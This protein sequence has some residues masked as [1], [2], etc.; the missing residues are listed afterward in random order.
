MTGKQFE[1]RSEGG[2]FQ[3]ALSDAVSKA[4]QS[5][6]VSDEHVRWTL[7]EV[8]GERGTIAGLNVVTVTI[9]ATFGSEGSK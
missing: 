8:K 6:G 5:T 9:R 2:D 4:E 7:A 3:E 1:G